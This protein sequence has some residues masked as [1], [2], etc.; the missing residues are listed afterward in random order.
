MRAFLA[1]WTAPGR[2]IALALLG[3]AAIA[4]SMQPPAL[5]QIPQPQIPPPGIRNSKCVVLPALQ[6]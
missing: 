2:L 6:G 4:F 3:L 1:W 5:R